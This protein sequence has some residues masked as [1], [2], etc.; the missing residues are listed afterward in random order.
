MHTLM[1]SKLKENIIL[2]QHDIN[3]KRKF[4]SRPKLLTE[5][6][7]F[8]IESAVDRNVSFRLKGT[9]YL[10]IN[11]VNI[12]LLVGNANR[13]SSAA[14]GTSNANLAV[15]LSTLEGQ[16][17]QYSTPSRQNRIQRRLTALESRLGVGSN[18]TWGSLTRRV[19]QLEIKM[20]RILV[21]LSSDNCTSNPCLHGGTC[22]NTFGGYTCQ[23]LDTW[24]GSNCEEDV[25]ECT[26]FANTDL[27]CQNSITC[28][29]TPGGYT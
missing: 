14:S 19:R 22:T 6:G 4:T 10:N 28:E 15:R 23:C 8:V 12:M 24:T 9:S 21:R 1:T 17:R 2:F 27:G 29:N 11:D 20:Q 25:N 5:N 13:S 26:A 7:N 16:F 18:A 3:Q